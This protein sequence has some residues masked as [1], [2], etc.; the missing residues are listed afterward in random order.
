MLRRIALASCCAIIG[1]A[2][3]TD[4]KPRKGG[5]DDPAA[6]EGTPTPIAQ[7]LAPEK[8]FDG[9]AV[10][11]PESDGGG[12]KMGGGGDMAGMDM[13]D[14]GMAG[15][16]MGGDDMAG[17]KMGGDDMAGMKMGDGGMAGMHKR[18]HGKGKPKADGGT[19]MGNMKMD[20]GGMDMSDGGM[21]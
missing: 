12:M 14:G 8:P 9:E 18:Q 19:G 10:K 7:T 3:V 11:E 13:G 15:M 6:A 17:M 16:K 4:Y 21:K 2:C 5:P 20:M 1:T